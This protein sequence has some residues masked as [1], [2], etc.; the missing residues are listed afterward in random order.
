MNQ[1]ADRMGMEDRYEAV[2]ALLRECKRISACFTMMSEED[3]ATVLAHPLVMVGCDAHTGDGASLFHPRRRTSFPRIL[4]RYVR[5]RGITSLPEMI[6][7]MTSLPAYVYRLTEKGRIAEG[8]DADLCI[9]DP[10]TIL[11]QADYANP[12]LPNI[13]LHYV[14]VGGKVVV[15]NG[16]YNGTRAGRIWFC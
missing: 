10:D 3:V 5:E 14:L 12:L 15:E 16:T 9:F 2:F 13:G 4:G 1:I 8:Y 6:R 11:E 7:K